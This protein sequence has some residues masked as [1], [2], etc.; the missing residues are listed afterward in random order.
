MSVQ[1]INCKQIKFSTEKKKQQMCRKGNFKKKIAMAT[2]LFLE[3]SQKNVPRQALLTIS[4]LC[5]CEK[6][7]K[8]CGVLEWER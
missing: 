1:H 6:A 5:K 2:I 7:G 3:I 4:K 8:I